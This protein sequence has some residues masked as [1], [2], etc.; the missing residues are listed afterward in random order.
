MVADVDFVLEVTGSDASAQNALAESQNKYLANMM[1][2]ILHAADLGPE[3]WSFGLRHAVYIKN[4]LPHV[5]IKKTPY[6]AMT[7]SKPD[8]TDL[9]TFGCR[10]HAKNPGK[11][12]AK[13]DHH[14][15]NGIFVGFTVT[16]KNVY[17][18]DDRT[19]NVKIGTHAT[20]D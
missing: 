11:R 10:V 8:I 7:N 4:R 6:E 1:R 20:L 18:I 3:Y 5:Y 13:I 15:S 16:T 12:P 9:R 19:L 2:C 17:F 14:T